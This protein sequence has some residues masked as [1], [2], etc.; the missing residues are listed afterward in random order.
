MILASP[1]LAVDW[2]DRIDTTR[3]QR[4]I[5]V[6]AG[7]VDFDGAPI[8]SRHVQHPD[9]E[10]ARAYLRGELASLGLDV[11]EE[12]FSAEGIRGVNLV[13]TLRGADPALEPVVVSAHYDSTADFTDGFDPTVDPAPGADDDASGCA[14]VL[15]AL[16]LLAAEPGF[17]R[18]IEFI[19]FDAEEEGLVGS[20][21]HVAQR[22]RGVHAM[23]SVDSVGSNPADGWVFL[24]VGAGAEHVEQALVE[25]SQQQTLRVLTQV[26]PVGAEFIGPARS[27]HG[28]FV[29]AG[30]PAAHLGQFPL[31]SSYHTAEDRTARLD[32][33]F[34][35]DNTAVV[36][37]ALEQLA[38]PHVGAGP[39]GTGCATA[40]SRWPLLGIRRRGPQLLR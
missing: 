17:R 23:L 26:R 33:E 9:R 12:A 6:L 14:V 30:L 15:E 20:T 7:E 37:A 34:I 3:Q 32:H 13:V 11:V 40:P 22:S 24:S 8:V 38:E 36:V 2:A 1:A 28:P 35:A 18:S 25:Q 21:V 27:D 4:W 10:R 16:T 29:A 19:L 31:P 5:D 39:R